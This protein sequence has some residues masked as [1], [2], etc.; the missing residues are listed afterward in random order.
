MPHH[1]HYVEPFAGGC[2]VLLAHTGEGRSELINDLDGRLTNFWRV[3]QNPTQFADLHRRLEAT[4]LSR[5][6]WTEAV[7]S[8]DEGDEIDQ[9]AAFFI[10]CRQSMAGRRKS[11]T[12]PTRK[13][14]RRD[15]N[16]NVSE[17]LGAIEGMPAVH[18]RLKRVFIESIDAIALM[19]REDTPGTFFYCDPPYLPEVRTSPNVYDHELTVE[20]HEAFLDVAM[21][22]EGKVMISGYPS[23]LYD[24][25]LAGWNR[26]VF[27][28]P[29]N[30][31]GGTEKRLMNEVVWMNYAT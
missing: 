6:E 8:L 4:P 30:A 20:Q 1:V 17:W 12:P 26:K 18:T 21:S 11:F 13:R 31:A 29:N 10:C 9:A 2:S 25:R 22:C 24:S 27:K 14:L 5:V 15:I 19:K 3:L 28:V 23:E 7:V 16:G